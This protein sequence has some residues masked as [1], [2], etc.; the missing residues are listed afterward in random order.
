[1]RQQDK[2]IIWPAYFDL[3]RTRR[4]GRQVPKNLA[5]EAPKALE[6]KAAAEKLGFSGEIVPDVAYSKTSNVKTGMIL[7]KKKEPKNQ[8]IRKIARQ[9]VQTRNLPNQK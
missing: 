5:V 3:T 8:A 6:V 9:L 7:I 2:I 1:M 4:Q